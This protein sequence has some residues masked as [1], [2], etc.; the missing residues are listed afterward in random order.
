MGGKRASAEV[1]ADVH[2]E[3]KKYQRSDTELSNFSTAPSSPRAE[4]THTFLNAVENLLQAAQLEGA[5]Q[6]LGDPCSRGSERDEHKPTA[7]GGISVAELT[8][9]PSSSSSSI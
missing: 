6:A 8:D 3:A 4:V 7:S 5:K 9:S 1:L 2:F